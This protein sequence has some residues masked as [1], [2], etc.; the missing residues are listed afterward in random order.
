MQSVDI[1]TDGACRGNPGPGGWGVLLR[2]GTATDAEERRLCGGQS[3]TT[4][5]RMELQAV[6]EGLTALKYPCRIALTTDSRYVQQG[7]TEWLPQW[8]RRNWRTAAGKAVRNQDL[9]QVLD[10]LVGAH[11]VEWHWIKGHSGHEGNDIAD[12]LAN[13]GIDDMVGK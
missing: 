1:F 10:E 12:K 7:F 3:V 4:N 11:Q 2:F 13:Q 8:K 6:I 5:N 9:W